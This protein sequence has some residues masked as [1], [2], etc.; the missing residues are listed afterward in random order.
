MLRRIF[1][2][3]GSSDLADAS[4]YGRRKGGVYSRTED[5]AQVAERR[6]NTLSAVANGMSQVSQGLADQVNNSNE[7]MAEAA[8]KQQ[9]QAQLANAAR[10]SQQ[11]AIR[12][13]QEQ[14]AQADRQ[15]LATQQLSQAPEPKYFGDCLKFTFK[16]DT[17]VETNDCGRAV[18]ARVCW[19]RNSGTWDCYLD[20]NFGAGASK[21]LFD[22]E[23]RTGKYWT[24]EPGSPV[25]WPQ[26]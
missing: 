21:E 6:A 3:D 22:S 2:W 26:P 13:A 16:S 24:R 4:D 7:A 10:Q 25:A 5:P 8:A 1:N 14:A 12:A 18:D 9:Q 23:T 19:Q 20:Q 15:Q 11:A 17:Y